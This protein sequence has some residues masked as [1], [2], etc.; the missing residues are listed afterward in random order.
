MPC[1][2]IDADED[3]VS[4]QYLEHKGDIAKRR[5]INTVM[6]KIIY[7]YEG[8]TNENGRNELV[9]EMHFGGVCEDRTEN[10][11]LWKKVSCYIEESYNMEA[12]KCIYVNGDGAA[13]IKAG[14]KQLE[15]AR[16]VLD[17]FHMHKYII[18]ATSHL[19]DSAEGHVSHIYADR[20]SSRPLGW[21]RTGADKMARLRVYHANKG[22]ML[23]LVRYQK[24]EEKKAVGAE[25]VIY[26]SSQMF[27]MEHANQNRLGSLADM[28]VYSIP[29]TQ[30]KKM[31]NFKNH[32][33]GL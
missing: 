13:W 3:H 14:A 15:K 28:P 27:A 5:R 2:Y 23:E 31:A 11:E 12:M 17:K 6:P 16:F 21:S 32:I 24:K 22:D 4:L 9:N 30:I 1:L 19:K 29:Y 10:E 8:I 33:W 20:M 25:E 18:A 7:V 26:T